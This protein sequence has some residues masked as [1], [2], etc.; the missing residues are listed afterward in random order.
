MEGI[1]VSMFMLFVRIRLSISENT[2]PGS[3]GLSANRPRGV[4]IPPIRRRGRDAMMWYTGLDA[5]YGPCERSLA[6]DLPWS[7]VLL[8][9]YVVATTSPRAGTVRPIGRPAARAKTSE[10]IA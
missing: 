4:G 7:Y 10:G 3:R 1:R 8:Y 9:S 6:I 5:Q 2:P